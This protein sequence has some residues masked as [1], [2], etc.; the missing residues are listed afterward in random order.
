[1]SEEVKCQCKEKAVKK[2]K[3]FLF[4][5]GGVFVGATLAI[6]VS[7]SILK[8]KCPPPPMGFIPPRPGFERQM[9][10]MMYHHYGPEF[11]G[12]KGNFCPCKGKCNCH[13]NNKAE[14]NPQ[15][16]DFQGQ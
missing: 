5:S 11:R 15:R 14:F 12:H 2:L 9:P 6:L 1:M 16:P 7:A 13:K 8:P 4:I 10:P 3:E